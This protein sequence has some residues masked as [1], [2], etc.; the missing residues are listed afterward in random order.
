MNIIKII[1]DNRDTSN[2]S[3]VIQ[4]ELLLEDELEE[5]EKIT[6][7]CDERIKCYKRINDE[8]SKYNSELE[9]EYFKVQDNTIICEYAK[10]DI[11]N[12]SE[13]IDAIIRWIS[14][15]R[16]LKELTE[17]VFKPMIPKVNYNSYFK[18]DIIYSDKLCIDYVI[19]VRDVKYKIGFL[20][21]K[22]Y[23]IQISN[24]IFNTNWDITRPNIVVCIKNMIP[25]IHQLNKV[26]DKELFIQFFDITAIDINNFLIEL[27]TAVGLFNNIKKNVEKLES[28]KINIIYSS[29]K[30]YL[31]L[32]LQ[33]G[34]LNIEFFIEEINSLISLINS[35]QL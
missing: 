8:V 25:I 31:K 9:F 34:I 28:I 27:E 26:E 11:T 2:M 23:K 20:C 16:I 29:K 24:I 15:Q 35:I 17:T 13:N 30:I 5:L 10:Y 12:L 7:L 19:E 1:K 21:D 22:I 4:K 14:Y 3:I 18:S 33:V 6:K 32:Y